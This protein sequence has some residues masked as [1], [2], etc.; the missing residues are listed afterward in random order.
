MYKTNLKNN[1]RRGLYISTPNK[2]YQQHE[3]GEPLGNHFVLESF[4]SMV[5]N[6]K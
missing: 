2:E 4:R 1:F 5:E 6:K 3:T